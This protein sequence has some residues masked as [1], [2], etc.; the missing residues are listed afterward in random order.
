MKS[1]NDSE[2]FT[3]LDHD[4]MYNVGDDD[5]GYSCEGCG[6]IVDTL[7]EVDG[8]RICLEC[9]EAIKADLI[10]EYWDGFLEAHKCEG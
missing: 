4:L 9:L 7:Y 5:E 2:L 6:S 10:E 1:T 3:A 8:E